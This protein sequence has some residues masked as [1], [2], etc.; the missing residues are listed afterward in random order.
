MKQTNDPT[1]L[2]TGSMDPY[3]MRKEIR[4]LGLGQGFKVLNP[5]DGYRKD[6]SIWFGECDQCGTRVSNGRF[7][8][9]KWVHTVKVD[10][11]NSATKHVE[12]CPFTI[13]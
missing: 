2:F 9:L 6:D 3:E 13:P 12:Y 4:E 10:G 7:F 8:G 5:E 1:A 11:S